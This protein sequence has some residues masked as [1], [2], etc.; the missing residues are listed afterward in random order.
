VGMRKREKRFS[1]IKRAQPLFAD[2][3]M[4]LRQHVTFGG[5]V[6]AYGSGQTRRQAVCATWYGFFVDSGL[7][8]MKIPGC[9]GRGIIRGGTCRMW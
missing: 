3:P 5:S 8:G 4:G 7:A 1:F 6:A 9:R 2:L